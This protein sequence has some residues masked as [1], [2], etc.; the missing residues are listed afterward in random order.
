MDKHDLSVLL[1]GT[2]M[3]RAGSQHALLR[4]GQGLHG[5]GWRV[6]AAFLYDK[7]GLHTEWQRQS[8]IP[9]ADLRSWKKK[10]GMWN[11][12]RLAGGA[13]RLVRL[14]RRER[15]DLIMT[16]TQHSNL[17]AIPLAWVAGVPLRIASN[18]GCIDGMPPWLSRMHGKMINSSLATCLVANSEHVRRQAI[19]LEKVDPAKIVVI[20]NGVP[21]TSEINREKARAQVCAEFN[22]PANV[23]LLVTVGRLT[24]QKG[25]VYLI[26]AMPRILQAHPNTHLLLIGEGELRQSLSNLA[27]DLGVSAAVHFLG[28]RADVG[29]LLSAA[30]VFVFPTLWE[31]MPNA[32]LEAMAA[33]I[34]VAASSIPETREI[35]KDGENGLL[36]TVEDAQAAAEAIQRLLG[37]R[38]L[39]ERL[40]KAGREYVVAHFSI[41]QMVSAYAVLFEQHYDN[42]RR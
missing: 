31:G 11:V 39:R 29:R 3:T 38:A 1:L 26:Q 17:I 36:F 21:L 24:R 14:M 23:H 19:S 40:G 20:P 6:S 5:R 4:L 15:F 25:H 7:D 9:I 33:G 32:L 16:Y 28:L 13:L 22:L 35:L 37:D 12:F 18:R 27:A 41:E 30:D 10:G 2:Q 42:L 34:P 8:G